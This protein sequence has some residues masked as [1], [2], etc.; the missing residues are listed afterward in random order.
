MEHSINAAICNP[1][2]NTAAEMSINKVSH[3]PICHFG[4]DKVMSPYPV[5]RTKQYTK[6]DTD[7]HKQN[8]MVTLIR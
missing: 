1:Q 5:L 7:V 6:I 2:V 8:E 3:R 4:V